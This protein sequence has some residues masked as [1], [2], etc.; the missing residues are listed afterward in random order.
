[1]V[2]TYDKQIISKKWGNRKYEENY[3]NKYINR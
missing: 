2:A 1:L 3:R